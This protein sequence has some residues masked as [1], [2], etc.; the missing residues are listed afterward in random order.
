ML[1]IQFVLILFLY[2]TKSYYNKFLLLKTYNR[3]RTLQM[4]LQINPSLKIFLN[5]SELYVLVYA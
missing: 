3:S 5:K 4:R 1:T 2:K